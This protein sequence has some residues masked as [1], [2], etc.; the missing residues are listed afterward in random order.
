MKSVW[1]ILFATG[2]LALSCVVPS[3]RHFHRVVTL[4]SAT[5]SLEASPL[6]GMGPL[7][8]VIL[9]EVSCLDEKDSFDDY[10]N[11]IYP[12]DIE[13]GDGNRTVL[14]LRCPKGGR[15][16]ESVEYIYYDQG[17]LGIRIHI[18][19]LLGARSEIITIPV[20]VLASDPDPTRSNM[21]KLFHIPG[22]G[23][24]Q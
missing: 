21:R 9:L 16:S 13:Y 1:I 8:V 19:D 10:E 5:F 6:I 15:T 3:A 4:P 22:E 12:V 7:H 23:V 14:E 18:R 2:F 20:Q 11:L 17:E 24:I